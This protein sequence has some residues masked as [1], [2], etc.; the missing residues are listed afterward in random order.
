[1]PCAHFIS[2]AFQVQELVLSAIPSLR[3]T[4]RATPYV[5]DERHTVLCVTAAV[6]PQHRVMGTTWR[7]GCGADSSFSCLALR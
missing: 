7:L 3:R 1:M 5:Q 6:I 2:S 4:V